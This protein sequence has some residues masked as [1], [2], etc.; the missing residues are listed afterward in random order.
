[1]LRGWWF[2]NPSAV[3]LTF[4]SSCRGVLERMCAACLQCAVLRRYVQV[5]F[6]LGIR[7]VDAAAEIAPVPPCSPCCG[8]TWLNFFPFSAARALPGAGP[9]LRVMLLR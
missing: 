8:G 3:V 7:N 2:Y 9:R 1:M 6:A 4:R 5:Q